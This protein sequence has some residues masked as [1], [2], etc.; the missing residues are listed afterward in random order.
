MSD[1]NSKNAGLSEFA[2]L[3]GTFTKYG[4]LL[5]GGLCLLMYSNEIG[6]FPEG[7]GIGEGLA[8]YLVCAGFL[9]VYSLYTV[10]CT[11]TGCLLLAWPTQALQR[12]LIRREASG[13]RR[14]EQNFPHANFSS[15]RELPVVALGVVGLIGHGIF[16]YFSAHPLTAFWFLLVPLAQGAGVVFLLIVTRRHRHFE[17]GL[18]LSQHSDHTIVTKR[19]DMITA[20]RIFFV[21]L[22]VGPLLTA[23]D[24]LFLVDAAFRLAQLRK[25]RATIHIKAP[26]AARVGQSTLP[27]SPSFLG[28]DYVE[29]KKVNVLLRSVGQ[30]VVIELPNATEKTRLSIPADAIYVE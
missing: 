20:R 15:M 2:G 5:V 8:F 4:T 24:R 18:L 28:G 26:W 9:I 23:P 10:L 17:S 12:V 29:F 7:V 14:V 13:G 21:W 3:I 25:D 22:V 1:T 16:I 6:Q 27:K 19:R 30:K 11:A